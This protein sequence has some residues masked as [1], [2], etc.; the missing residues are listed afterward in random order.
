MTTLQE[1]GEQSLTLDSLAPIMLK[2]ADGWHQVAAFVSLTMRRKM[3]IVWKR[4][5]RSIA[6]ATQHPMLNLAILPVFDISNPAMEE[7]DNPGWSTSET[8]S[9]H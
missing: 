6:A 7:E 1:M 9:S 5:K 2:S 4:Q 3:K 8:Y